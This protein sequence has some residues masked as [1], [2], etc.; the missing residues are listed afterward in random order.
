MAICTLHYGL[1]S[2]SNMPS[3]QYDVVYSGRT[4]CLCNP[5]QKRGEQMEEIP[6]NVE[7]GPKRA[8]IMLP[9]LS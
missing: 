2:I 7:L 6:R 5:P 8:D 1:P 9:T 4:D 3:N